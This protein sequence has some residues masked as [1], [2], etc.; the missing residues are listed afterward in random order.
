MGET[1]MADFHQDRVVTTL[2]ALYEPLGPEKYPT[3]LKGKL[4]ELR[5]FYA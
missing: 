4:N 3:D 2:H 5:N 1:I